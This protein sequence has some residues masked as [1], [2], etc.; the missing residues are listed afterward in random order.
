LLLLLPLPLCEFE[1]SHLRLELLLHAACWWP[2]LRAQTASRSCV[3][4]PHAAH[5]DARLLLPHAP[6]T[7]RVHPRK[8]AWKWHLNKNAQ[9][10]AGLDSTS[11]C[12]G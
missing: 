6:G 1:G 3:S 10:S 12:D 4:K 8:Q 9:S 7:G 5:L 2:A 11:F